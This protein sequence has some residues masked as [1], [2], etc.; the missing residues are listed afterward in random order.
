MLI[1]AI[2][3]HS[4]DSMSILRIS[5]QEVLR[6]NATVTTAGPESFLHDHLENTQGPIHKAGTDDRKNRLR[7]PVHLSIDQALDR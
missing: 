2:R 7:C 4:N 1:H 3:P 6:L 5:G